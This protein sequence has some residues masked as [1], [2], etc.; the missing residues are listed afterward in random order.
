MHCTDTK[1][2]KGHLTQESVPYDPLYVKF[3]SREDQTFLAEAG[4]G[5]APGE[6]GG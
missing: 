5:L 1:F 6:G 4:R 3:E 2:R